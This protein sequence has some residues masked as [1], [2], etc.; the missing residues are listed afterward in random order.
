MALVPASVR[1]GPYPATPACR[2]S[3]WRHRSDASE[4][5]TGVFVRTRHGDPVSSCLLR[6]LAAFAPTGFTMATLAD[7]ARRGLEFA[8]R[9]SGAR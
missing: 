9:T 7:Y 8:A 5:G 2:I 3:R 1:W 4:T 6:N